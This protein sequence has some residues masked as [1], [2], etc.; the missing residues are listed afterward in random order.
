MYT[1]NVRK[2]SLL[3]L[4]IILSS[5]IILFSSCA[6]HFVSDRNNSTN[7]FVSENSISFNKIS[8]SVNE[9][10]TCSSND[11]KVIDEL[12]DRLPEISISKNAAL[13]AYGLE[14]QRRENF[15]NYDVDNMILREFIFPNDMTSIRFT[16]TCF[17]TDIESVKDV[18]KEKY[19]NADTLRV[20][21]KPT[22]NK[23]EIIDKIPRNEKVLVISEIINSEGEKWARICTYK[24]YDAYVKYDYLSDEKIIPQIQNN[25]KKKK[26]DVVSSTTPIKVDSYIPPAKSGTLN[27]TAG[28]TYGPSGKESYYNL[29]MNKVISGM[30]SR[31]YNYTYWVREDGVKMY[32][33]YVMVAANLN[34]RPK[35][36]LVETTLGTGIVCDTGSFAYKDS[37]ALDIAT[38]W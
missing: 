8:I 13:S 24:Y 1:N 35:G 29:N 15:D 27:R 10:F 34:L 7:I 16:T 18:C 23:S 12:D 25:N 26:K 17:S 20:R 30:Q 22:T 21:N 5:I 11:I 4:C 36:S 9:I 3:L 32:G 37:T 14:L 2:Y 6:I 38:T 28:I 19:I 33:D 31:G